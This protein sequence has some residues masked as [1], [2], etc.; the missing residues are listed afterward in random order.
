[1]PF[2]HGTL[3]AVHRDFG[4]A[5][6][7]IPVLPDDKTS[8][9]RLLIRGNV[10]NSGKANRRLTAEK[11]RAELKGPETCQRP[12][13]TQVIWIKGSRGR[14]VWTVLTDAPRPAG[15]PI[16]PSLAF[17]SLATLET[18]MIGPSREVLGSA[19][20]EDSYLVSFSVARQVQR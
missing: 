11:G 18:Q 1:M 10:G 6:L 14:R 7:Y 15:Q 17:T 19:P 13:T 4:G 9:K 12:K 3:G 20:L 5:L 2:G 16:R 8:S